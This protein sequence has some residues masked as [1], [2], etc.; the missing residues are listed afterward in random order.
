MNIL[1]YFVGA[2]VVVLS[3]TITWLALGMTYTD[4]HIN[5]L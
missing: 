3:G 2:I 4:F 1:P 5:Y